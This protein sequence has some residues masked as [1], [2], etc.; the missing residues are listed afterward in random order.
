MPNH[1]TRTEWCSDR[2]AA[3][4]SVEPGQHLGRRHR[5]VQ[6]RDRVR[7][8]AASSVGAGELGVELARPD[9]RLHGDLVEVREVTDLVGDGPAGR[10]G[11][12]PPALLVEAGHEQPQRDRL[13]REVVGERVHVSWHEVLR[14][15]LGGVCRLAR[16]GDDGQ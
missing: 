6:V 8:D 7:V 10:R 15:V 1:G 3:S 16:R 12:L 14:S 11:G 4:S 9:G 13:G 5:P 2:N